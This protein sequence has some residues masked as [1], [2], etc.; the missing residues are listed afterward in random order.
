MVEPTA[1]ALGNRPRR[2]RA[3]REGGYWYWGG[4]LPLV[5]ASVAGIVMWTNP[6][7]RRRWRISTGDITDYA[8]RTQHANRR[9][10]TEHKMKLFTSAQAWKPLDNPYPGSIT[11]SMA[12]SYDMHSK[13]T[14]RHE[15]NQQKHLDKSIMKN[16]RGW[17]LQA[18]ELT[19]N[20][21]F[22]P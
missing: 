15:G 13:V 17:V 16:W 20:L 11:Q 2:W 3:Y 1:A 14:Y 7:Q 10:R 8:P 9:W 18:L 22:L 5:I 21:N 4:P 6:C 12:G 19:P